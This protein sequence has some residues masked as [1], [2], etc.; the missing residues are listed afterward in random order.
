MQVTILV[1]VPKIPRH[2]IGILVRQVSKLRV[3]FNPKI[4]SFFVM[5]NFNPKIMSYF[6]MGNFNS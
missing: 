5:G 2:N 3:T 1:H 6:V 4:M